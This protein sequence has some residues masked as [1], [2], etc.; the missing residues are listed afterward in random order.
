[1]KSLAGEPVDSAGDELL[2]DVLTELVVEL[3]AL[4]D[5][6]GGIVVLLV[7]GRARGV[8]EVEERLCGN[9]LLDNAGLLCVCL[10]LACCS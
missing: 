2:L 4:L 6:G 3:E 1:L 10:G 5:V 8:E 7:L 9:G